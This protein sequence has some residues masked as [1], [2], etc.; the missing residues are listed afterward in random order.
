MAATDSIFTIGHST[1]PIAAFVE[2]LRVGKVTSVVDIRSISRSRA[3]PQYNRDVLPAA[4]A[5]CQI[6]YDEIP[7]LGGLRKK[8]KTIP[9]DVNGFWTNRS[10][11]NYADYALS[12]EFRAGLCRLLELAASRRCAIMCAE[13]VWWRCHRRIVADYLLHQNRQV[14]HLMGRSRAEPAVMTAAA[15]VEAAGLVYPALPKKLGSPT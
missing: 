7:E 1:K 6:S 14:F 11:H 4:L 9:P 8:S 5:S 13:A 10:F 2:L 12:A 15:R 3:N